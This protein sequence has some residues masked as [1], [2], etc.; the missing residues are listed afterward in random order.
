MEYSGAISFFFPCKFKDKGVI[1]RLNKHWNKW[2]IKREAFIKHNNEPLT[3][4]MD[5]EIDREWNECMLSLLQSSLG[6][7]YVDSNI[8]PYALRCLKTAYRYRR[9]DN[10][11]SK[12]VNVVLS[13]FQL[14]YEDK[15]GQQITCDGTLLLNVNADNKV[16]TFIVTLSLDGLPTDKI[17]ILKHVLYKRLKVSIIEYAS[18]SSYDACCAQGLESRNFGCFRGC[19]DS[20]SRLIETAPTIPQYILLKSAGLLSKLECE[21]DFRARYS[22]MDVKET[23]PNNSLF[24][25]EKYIYG[26][27]TADEMYSCVPCKCICNT[28]K[29]DI[30][31]RNYHSFYLN[32]QNGLIIYN[33]DKYKEYLMGKQRFKNDLL[34]PEGYINGDEVNFGCCIPGVKENYFPEF[35]KSVELHYLLNLIQT[36][37]IGHREQ[38]FWNLYILFRRIKKLWNVIYELDIN[39]YHINNKMLQSFGVYKTM[40]EIR[41]EFNMTLGHIIGYIGLIITL[42]QIL[43]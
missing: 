9:E 35:L 32:G 33:E 13:C 41:E 1:R 20:S 16:G 29:N 21:I 7:D 27:L 23:F 26:L 14:K 15:K 38:S 5:L 25:Q 31:T 28:I 12:S 24:C 34:S 10:L 30:S 3:D 4:L 39:K 8:S 40:K 11:F 18:S 37:E 43:L 2:R 17:I 42:L 36:N 19:T 22:L 6:K